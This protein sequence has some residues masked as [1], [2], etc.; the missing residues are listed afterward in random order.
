MLSLS[1]LEQWHQRLAHCSPLTIKDMAT[2]NL[3]DGLKISKEET[4]G[5]CID[6]ILGHQTHRPFDGE[7]EKSLPPLDLISFDLWGPSCVQSIGG[8]LYL[9]IIVDGGTSFKF[10]A[11]LSDKLDTTTLAVFDVFCTKAEN[12]TGRKI[13]RLREQ[14]GLLT[15]GPGGSVTRDMASP[16]NSLRLTPHPR[17]D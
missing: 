16:M 14:M 8:K 6:C 12:L 10:G 5:K 11:Y 4:N 17:M 3:V 2:R 7:T 13:H 15:Q 1:P 9:M